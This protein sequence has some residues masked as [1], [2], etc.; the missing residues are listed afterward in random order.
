MGSYRAQARPVTSCVAQV[1]HESRAPT[2]ARALLESGAMS[3]SRALRLSK[4]VRWCWTWVI[5]TATSSCGLG[6]DPASSLDGAPQI[7]P[8]VQVGDHCIPVE[9]ATT[10]C[11]VQ[12]VVPLYHATS[13]AQLP[14]LLGGFVLARS[15]YRDAKGPFLSFTSNLEDAFRFGDERRDPTVGTV[16]GFV[17]VLAPVD[18]LARLA[19]EDRI[20]V[21]RQESLLFRS[22]RGYGTFYWFRF[23]DVTDLNGWDR[24]AKTENELAPSLDRW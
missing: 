9:Q 1:P 6:A 13:E 15:K 24:D 8:C 12:L 14:S 10:S 18:E 17:R 7:D 11:G 22:L 16:L 19:A 5:A 21:A 4:R 20:R 3:A 2:L 23:Y